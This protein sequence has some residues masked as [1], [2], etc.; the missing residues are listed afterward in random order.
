MSN[1]RD[2]LISVAAAFVVVILAG[3]IVTTV[4]TAERN[5]RKA[6]ESLQ[7]AQLNQLSRLLDGALG[8]ALKSPAG[9]TNPATQQ[10]WRLLANDPTDLAG[11]EVLQRSN[12]QARTGWVLLDNH[13]VVTTG[14]LLTDPGLVAK[15]LT[16]SG[17]DLV[18]SGTPS[19]LPTATNSLTT[20]LPTIVIARPVRGGGAGTTGPVRGAILNESDVASDSLFTQLMTSFRRAKTDA[21]SFIDS[22]NVV[23]ASTDPSLVGKPADSILLDPR[24]GFHRHGR[25]VTATAVIPSAGWRA[26]Y[27]QSR[28]EF[29]GSITGPLRSALLLLIFIGLFGAGLTFFAL[30]SRLRAAR[31]EQ[32]RLANINL[33]REEFISIV[34]HELRT[35]ATGQLGFLQTLLDHWDGLSDPERRQTVTQAYTNARRLHALTRDVLDTASIEAGELPYVFE[36]VDL[37]P[38]VREAVE[39]RPTPNQAIVMSGEDDVL[40]VRADPERLQQVL[41]NLLD[42]AVKHSPTGSTIDVRVAAGEEGRAMVEVSD[43]GTG[44]TEEELDRAF[45]KFSRGRHGTVRGT[46]LGLYISRMIVDAHGGR[47]WASRRAGGGATVAFTL[48]LVSAGPPEETTPAGTGLSR[49]PTPAVP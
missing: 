36:V 34:S 16:R 20:P 49:P 9:L 40:L 15:P 38:A 2:R 33:A 48:P 42:N 37:R 18:L 13:G 1:R 4:L 28:S 31:Q 43:R 19:L 14:T 44:I 45:E 46:G 12:P 8:P 7:L 21:Y 32:E 41:A 11:L 27:R 29:E 30:V 6:L 10:P 24:T 26:V 25:T 39:A 3:S 22:N 23:V 17:L 35:P 5:G 47:I